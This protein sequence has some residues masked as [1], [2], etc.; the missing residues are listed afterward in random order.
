[1]ERMRGP[2]FVDVAGIDEA[3]KELKEI[4]R[5]LRESDRYKRIVARPC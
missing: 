5:A 2:K 3:K 1:M 4:V